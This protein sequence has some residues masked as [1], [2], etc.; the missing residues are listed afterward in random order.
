MYVWYVYTHKAVQETK[1][2]THLDE[3]TWYPAAGGGR[4]PVSDAHTASR[5]SRASRNIQ[6]DHQR[7]LSTVT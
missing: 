1:S 5:G 7:V 4:W 6:L 3:M 2:N